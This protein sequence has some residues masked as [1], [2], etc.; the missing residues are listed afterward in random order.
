MAFQKTNWEDTIKDATGNI[1]RKGTPLSA[2]N[3]NNIEA[4]IVE[5][6]EK[7]ADIVY[8]PKSFGAVGDGIVDDT[9]ALQTAANKADLDKAMLDLGPYTYRITSRVSFGCHLDG[10]H[11]QI[12][13]DNIANGEAVRIGY[14]GNKRVE[15]KIFHTPKIKNIVTNWSNSSV[16][17]RIANANNCQIH[18][19]RVEGFQT[20]L[21]LIG[22]ATGHAYNNYFIGSLV[23]GKINLLLETKSNGWINENNLFIGR[24]SHLSTSGVNVEGCRHI[25]LYS[26]LNGIN[27]NS[28][29]KAVF[30]G[31]AAEYDLE[32]VNASYNHFINSRWESAK[33]EVLCGQIDSTR[34]SSYNMFLY[35]YKLENVKIT[36]SIDCRANNVIANRDFAKFEGRYVTKGR[37]S[38]SDTVF[39]A[40]DLHGSL[41]SVAPDKYLLN[42][43]PIMYKGKRKD[44]LFP[45]IAINNETGKILLGSGLSEPFEAMQWNSNGATFANGLYILN[46]LWNSKNLRFGLN[47]IWEDSS[48][49][50]RLKHNAN[51]TSDTDGTLIGIKRITTSN[52][53][54]NP[55]EGDSYI[56]TT[57]K[58]IIWWDGTKWLDAMGNEV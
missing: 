10:K 48:G 57:V 9:V 42:I 15:D 26:E 43:S 38:N 39:E 27:N 45:R 6:T 41:N 50:L 29:Y 7:L 22:D 44:D 47:R 55:K 58:K 25:K 12:I 36:E 19:F 17:L 51:P 13:A 49:N 46:P 28:F 34:A 37:S 31:V 56:D 21:S 30:E 18:V 23:D 14:T 24:L 3:L 4:G 20:N 11:A 33:N 35:G 2:K 32:L 53:P 8:Q 40:Y 54:I 1:V 16:G 52:R 5:V